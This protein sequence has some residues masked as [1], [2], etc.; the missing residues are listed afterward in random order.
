MHVPAHAHHTQTP[1]AT[2]AVATRAEE[3]VEQQVPGYSA[4][5]EGSGVQIGAGGYAV[6]KKGAAGGPE[7]GAGGAGAA[8]QDDVR[9]FLFV[10]SLVL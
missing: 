10:G 4:P 8:P 5:A 1:T 9:S 2:A 3:G 6:E 7:E